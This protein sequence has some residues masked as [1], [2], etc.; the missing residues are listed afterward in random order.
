MLKP[1]K[2]ISKRELKEDKFVTLTIQVK[3][4]LEKN[5]KMLMYAGLAV[6]VIIFLVSFFIRSKK[7][8]NVTANELLGKASFSF[9]QG[10]ESGG[11]TQLKELI[12]NYD[13]VTAAG[14]GCYLLAKYYWQKDDFTN[15]KIYF[16]QYLDD[17]AEDPLLSSGA[18]AGFA[19]CLYQEGNLEEAAR[20]YENAARVDKNLPMAPSYLFSAAKC[21]IELNDLTKAKGLAA[22]II[23]NY[24]DS[25]YKS[26]AEYLLNVIKY[27]V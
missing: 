1:Y 23:E 17:Y 3:E 8:A 4:Y 13:G 20:H 14:Q 22:E 2:K 9:S 15:A 16:K 12:Q 24:E 10:N 21:F 25:E 7:Q 5:G 18:H 19:D 26:R 6:V 11:E 27:K